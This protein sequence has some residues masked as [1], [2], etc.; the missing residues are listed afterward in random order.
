MHSKGKELDSIEVIALSKLKIEY[1][2][3][4]KVNINNQTKQH[5]NSDTSKELYSSGNTIKN[6]F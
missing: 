1:V 5:M 3:C 2:V 6:L 4:H